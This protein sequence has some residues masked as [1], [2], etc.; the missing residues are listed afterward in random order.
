MSDPVLSVYVNPGNA[1]SE[2]ITELYVALAAYYLSLGG[3][4]LE[5]VGVRR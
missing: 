5:I 3:T 2:L 1:T 4:G